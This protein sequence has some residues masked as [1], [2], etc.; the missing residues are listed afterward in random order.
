LRQ[1]IHSHFRGSEFGAADEFSQYSS[2]AHA[3]ALPVMA[4]SPSDR[5][6]DE[7]SSRVAVQPP[8]C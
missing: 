1:A 8:T 4:Y 2:L 5:L 6:A 3:V 7:S